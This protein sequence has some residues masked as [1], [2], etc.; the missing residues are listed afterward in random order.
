MSVLVPSEG[1][2]KGLNVP[3]KL[4]ISIVFRRCRAT[5]CDDCCRNLPVSICREANKRHASHTAC[6]NSLQAAKNIHESMLDAVV[7]APVNWY[8]VTPIGRILNR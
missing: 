8:D 6:L 2:G 4:L 1:Q 5:R 7:R 3:T